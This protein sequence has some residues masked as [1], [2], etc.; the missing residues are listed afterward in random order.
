MA[1][2]KK[3]MEPVSLRNAIT[4]IAD[5]TR[6]LFGRTENPIVIVSPYRMNPLGAHIDHQG[7]SVLARTIDQYTI[8]AVYPSDSNRIILHCDNDDLSQQATAFEMQGQVDGDNWVRYAKASAKCFSTFAPDVTGFSGVVY[9]TLVG[10]GLSSSASVILAYLQALAH[11]NRVQLGNADLVELSRQVENEHMGLNNGLQ[12]QMSV[13]FGRE[14]GLSLLDMNSVSAQYIENPSSV[15]DVS[16]VICYSGFSRELVY[17]GFNDRVRECREAAAALDKNATRLGEVAAEFRTEQHLSR[18]PSHLAR[19][20]QH[21]YSEMQRV[22]NA[23]LAWQQGDWQTFG[24]LMNESCYSSINHYECGSDA[25]ID[26]HEIALTHPAVY[27]SRFGGGGYGGCLMMLSNSEHQEQVI[28]D[29]LSSYLEK[30][31]DKKGI[32]KAFV[33]QAESNV[34]V[35]RQ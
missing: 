2:A 27:G 21:V 10:A 15:A 3:E 17:S 20:V 23:C 18:L 35:A 13:V 29:V 12:D 25:M 34:R 30:F 28:T 32:A 11:I 6:T 22:E 26:L 7:G 31:P 19:R 8:L 33:A 5:K 16:W 24:R 4:R 9:G 14:H 1:S